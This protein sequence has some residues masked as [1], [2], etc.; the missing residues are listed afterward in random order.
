MHQAF[1]VLL[2]NSGTKFFQFLVAFVFLLTADQMSRLPIVTECRSYL[3]NPLIRWTCPF[4]YLFSL[5]SWKAHSNLRKQ[6]AIYYSSEH[7]L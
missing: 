6:L 1:G 5:N 2:L 7:W 4:N 3:R